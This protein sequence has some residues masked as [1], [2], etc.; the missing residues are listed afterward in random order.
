MTVRTE[1]T[2]ILCCRE[3]MSLSA[4]DDGEDREHSH[5]MVERQCHQSGMVVGTE[6]TRQLCCRERTPLSARDDRKDREH[7][8]PVL[9]RGNVVVSQG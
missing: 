3:G 2:R 6:G 9:Q 7:S 1:S 5:P 4:R 8:H